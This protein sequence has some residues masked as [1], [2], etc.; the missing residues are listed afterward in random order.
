MLQSFKIHSFKFTV[1]GSLLLGS[2]CVSAHPGSEGEESSVK[3][4]GYRHCRDTTLAILEE[5]NRQL[6]NRQLDGP[7]DQNIEA[8]NFK[9]EI[10]T[11]KDDIQEI[12]TQPTGEHAGD[13]PSSEK[14]ESM[15]KLFKSTLCLC[16]DAVQILYYQKSFP[17]VLFTPNPK[18][19]SAD[20]PVLTQQQKYEC[21]RNTT[22]AMLE[23]ADRQLDVLQ[24]QE[25][26]VES[27]RRQ[28][29]AM[30]ASI[31]EVDTQQTEKY[32]ADSTDPWSAKVEDMQEHFRSA[33]FL[34]RDAT[35]ANPHPIFFFGEEDQD[36][37][38]VF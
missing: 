11:A 23:E 14:T 12:D 24:E 26:D 29:A 9:R 13:D 21:C 32:T 19:K 38:E 10:G 36:H 6:D 3:Q 35:R 20:L 33:L 31:E 8:E 34:C 16:T 7:W 2:L 28:I 4:Q 27:E 30:K 17:S 18:E 5:T 22:L 1:L 15:Q 37:C 25:I